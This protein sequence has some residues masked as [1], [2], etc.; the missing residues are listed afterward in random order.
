M[1]AQDR[2]KTIG[3]CYG[4]QIL[5][6]AL[7]AKVARSESGAWEVSVCQ[8][9][10][11]ETGKE[12]FGGK[13]SLVSRT[14]LPTYLTY[15]P[16]SFPTPPFLTRNFV[17]GG[18]KRKRVHTSFSVQIYKQTRH[19]KPTNH[20]RTPQQS[21]YQMHRDHVYPPLPPSSPPVHL[22]GSSPA[23]AIQGMYRP[24]AFITVQGH[25]EFTPDVVTELLETRMEQGVFG[26]GIFEEG[27]GRVGGANDGVVVAGAW[28]RFLS[29]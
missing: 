21:I 13:D 5:G 25:P 9:A 14:H 28:L 4:H 19:P 16:F 8:V 3:V 11:T 27:M 29:G 1:L 18:K 2:V 17:D 20:P 26:A 15:Y 23:C 6:R 12:L 10:Q 7:G 22:L 24:R